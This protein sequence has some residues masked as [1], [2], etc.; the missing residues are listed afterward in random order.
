MIQLSNI[1]LR[2]G[3]NALLD[4]ANA[5]IFPG[6]KVG[7]VG[8]NGAG[9]SSFFALLRGE[10]SLDGG[11][12]S[13]PDNW[14]IAHMS[15]ELADLGKP[16]IE[17]VLDGD[18]EFRAAEKAIEAAESES[19]GERIAHA[20]LR[21]E[22]ADGYTARARAGELLNGLGFAA[23]EHDRPVREFSGGW[24]VRLGL[25]QALMCPSDLLLLDE[26]TNH[27]DLEAVMWLEDWLKSYPGTLVLVSHDREFLDGVVNEILHIEQ[28]KLN[29][30]TGGYSDFER[31][32]AANLACLQVMYEKQ[33]REIAHMQK[34]VDR[35]RY[36]ASKAKAAQSRIKALERMEKLAP[37]HVD[38]PFRFE[39]PESPRAVDPLIKLDDVSLGYGEQEVLHGITLSISTGD[40]IGLLGPNGAGKSTFIRA[41]AGELAPKTGELLVGANVR[42]GYFAQH[43]LEQ[44]DLEASPLLHLKRLSPNATEQKLRNFLGGFDFRGDM[45]TDPVAPRSGGEKSR[46]VLA[47]LAWQAPNVLLLD[48]P[49]NNLDL[50]MRHALTMALQ[51]FA[52][53]VITVSHDRHLLQSTVDSHLLVAQGNVREF[54]GDLSDYR[55]WLDQQRLGAK[56]GAASEKPKT[57]QAAVDKKAARRAA[58]EAR[59]AIHPLR[60]KS[61]KF[62][63]EIDAK[64]TELKEAE[65]QLADPALYQ[66]ENKS[67]LE[68]LLKR[69]AALRTA[70]EALELEW[71]EVEDMIE[72]GGLRTGRPSASGQ[73]R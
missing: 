2:R 63:S 66:A 53:A 65:R 18:R 58:A 69:Q 60:I 14:V 8:A 55:K 11:S 67:K 31:Q 36:K 5:T 9:K 37:A 10:L 68:P 72:S 35:F 57:A 64:A 59:T 71:A 62:M 49:T 73:D 32:R 27:L 21:Y 47:L 17:V 33:Q 20:H 39:F 51:G 13:I 34:F 24:R 12:V 23:Y 7:L 28:R 41:L 29:H 40:R 45:A 43:Q 30:Y 19:H 25:A 6:H 26:P 16:A 70:I 4:D 1:T 46:L 54:D 52:G 3:T 61:N 56:S 42:I 15:Q 22:N 38:S 48:E 44:L 50:E